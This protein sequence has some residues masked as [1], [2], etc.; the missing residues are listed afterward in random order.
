M[1]IHNLAFI[2]TETTG[3]DPKKHEIIE[4][5]VKSRAKLPVKEEVLNLR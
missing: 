5:A 2:D 1:K 3:T 4:L